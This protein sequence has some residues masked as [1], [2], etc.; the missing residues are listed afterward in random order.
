MSL[1]TFTCLLFAGKTVHHPGCV[2]GNTGG[3]VEPLPCVVA[4]VGGAV[5]GVRADYTTGPLATLLET[6]TGLSPIL[7]VAGGGEFTPH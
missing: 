1:S 7:P 5:V 3:D 4:G 2:T 6:R